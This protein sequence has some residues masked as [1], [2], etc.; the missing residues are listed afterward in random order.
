MTEQV[1][2]Q[3]AL[4]DAGVSSRRA[5]EQL[6][7]QG[8]VSVNG[9]PA[10]IGQRVDPARD[11]IAVDGRSIGGPSERLY[12][13]LAKPAGVTSTVSDRHAGQTVVELVP[14]EL[15]RRAAR[16]YPVGRLD[17]DSEGLL[18]LTN[19][20]EWAQRLLHPSH[21]VE[22]EYAIG[23]ERPLADDQRRAL[24]AGVTLEEGIATL[25]ALRPA[26]AAEV[27]LLAPFVGPAAAQLVWYRAILH[28]G[29][30]RQ[31]RRMFAAVGARV[32]RLVRVRFGTL[33]LTGMAA[34][35]VRELTV[36]E[37]H[38]LDALAG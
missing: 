11:S 37:R 25:D 28:Q 30:K 7:E 14:L 32:V 26:T 23:L 27:R 1:R 8:R 22:R 13:V 5:A 36:R 24:E 34:G 29:W 2:I 10:S 35:E 4:A 3:K 15:R 38:Q 17:R 19:D 18:L 9:Q 31:L 20:G 33:R 12:L 6:I 21:A 16:L